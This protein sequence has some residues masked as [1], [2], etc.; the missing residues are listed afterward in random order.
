MVDW[1]GNSFEYPCIYIYVV[2]GFPKYSGPGIYSKTPDLRPPLMPTK[3]G[4]KSG[5]VSHQEL[6]YIIKCFFGL[7]EA[8][9]SHRVIS[10]QDGLSS[11]VLLY[12]YL[13]YQIWSFPVFGKLLG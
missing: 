13:I 3:S 11:G 10:G 4:L 1:L 12:I 6:I 5:V 2:Y 9:L 7:N 8:V